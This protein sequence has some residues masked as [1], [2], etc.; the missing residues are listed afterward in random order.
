ML[1][2]VKATSRDFYARDR[3]W[4]IEGACGA[5]DK[6]YLRPADALFDII[7]LLGFRQTSEP[8][9]G[10]D[11]AATKTES[12][13][14]VICS[15]LRDKLTHPE[16]AEGVALFSLAQQYAHIRL[17][18]YSGFPQ[19]GPEQIEEAKRYAG[20]FLVPR[21]QVF[22]HPVYWDMIEGGRA[23]QCLWEHVGHLAKWFGVTRGH[24]V[25][26]LEFLNIVRLDPESREL[27]L[28][29]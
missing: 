12:K 8:I 11:Y 26:E 3:N 14:I 21:H 13:K 27:R 24:L 28:A 7:R 6:Q 29:A 25:R 22:E 4:M 17:H 16:A 10:P 1:S 2:L 20:V 23:G 19:P 9:D 5:L 18:Y 15:H